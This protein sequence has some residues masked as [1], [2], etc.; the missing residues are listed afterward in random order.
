MKI[1]IQNYE[2]WFLLKIDGE[3]DHQQAAALALFLDQ[4]PELR[5]ELHLLEQTKLPIPTIVFPDKSSLYKKETKKAALLYKMMKSPAVAAILIGVILFSWGILRN[6]PYKNLR[7]LNADV[8]LN[9]VQTNPARILPQPILKNTSDIASLEIDKHV[10]ARSA[11]FSKTS[12]INLADDQTIGY[13]SESDSELPISRNQHSMDSYVEAYGVEIHSPAYNLSIP[14]DAEKKFPEQL[15]SD[16]VAPVSIGYK[17]LETDDEQK[18]LYIGSS[19][20]NR[21][22]LRSFIR[23]AAILLKTKSTRSFNYNHETNE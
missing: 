7:K 1:T 9:Q 22:Q 20:I 17:E 18:T 11:D 3:L 23:K 6:S 5:Q 4:H 8:V 21:D 13:S 15:S 12:L 14:D 10:N 2:T 16:I 19:E